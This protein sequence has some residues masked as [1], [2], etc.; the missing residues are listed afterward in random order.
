MSS[1]LSHG[2]KK[3]S[4]GDRGSTWF[5]NLEDNIDLSNSHDHDGTD[6]EQIAAKYI[7]KAT[8][9]IA[10]GS[11]SAVAGQAGTYKQTVSL[12]SGYLMSTVQI[13][14]LDASGHPLMLS[15]EKVSSTSYDVYINDNSL[16]LTAVYG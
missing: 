8:A 13:H 2:Y 4:N 1:T 5:S 7:S 15:V 14:F 11:W 12:P 16:T 10:S 3:P 9:S 6:G